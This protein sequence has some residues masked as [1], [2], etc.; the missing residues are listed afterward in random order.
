MNFLL[1]TLLTHRNVMNVFVIFLQQQLRRCSVST[2]Q[3]GSLIHFYTGLH[4]VHGCR[5]AL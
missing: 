1:S 5:Y 2:M 4:M 3:F